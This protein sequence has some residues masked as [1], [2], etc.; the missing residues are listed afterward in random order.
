MEN[1]RIAIRGI[2]SVLGIRPRTV[3]KQIVA[4]KSKGILVRMGGTRGS[5][6]VKVEKQV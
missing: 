5:W 3:E 1:P 2:A 6:V 4:L